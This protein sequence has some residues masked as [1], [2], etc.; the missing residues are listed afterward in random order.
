[1]VQGQKSPCDDDEK[2]G[3]G[4]QRGE[5]GCL[6]STGGGR[7]V[8]ERKANHPR[9]AGGHEP[10]AVPGAQRGWRQT[11]VCLRGGSRVKKLHQWELP[12]CLGFVTGVGEDLS[13]NFSDEGAMRRL[14]CVIST[15]GPSNAAFSYLAEKTDGNVVHPDDRFLRQEASGGQKEG[16]G[17]RRS[18]GRMFRIFSKHKF[19][20]EPLSVGVDEVG[21]D[22][23]SR[24]GIFMRDRYGDPGA[25]AGHVVLD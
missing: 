7:R 18:H 2:R 22:I 19:H 13:E 21:D 17:K 5:F 20:A 11:A 14:P 4:H 23:V 10:P 24:A 3:F 15:S 1:M 6:Y 9:G 8:G 12:G 25:S 16:T